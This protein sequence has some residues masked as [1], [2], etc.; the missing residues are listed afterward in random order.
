V[1]PLPSRLYP[2]IKL[3]S[4]FDIAKYLRHTMQS[5]P[6]SDSASVRL[7]T[8]CAS[9]PQFLSAAPEKRKKN[10]KKSVDGE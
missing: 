2:Y 1:N 10:E 7:K 9:F 4:T 5:S 8:L 3:L 6:A